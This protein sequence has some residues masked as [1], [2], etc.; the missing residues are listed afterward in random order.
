MMLVGTLVQL[1]FTV[2]VVNYSC[3]RCFH[4]DSVAADLGFVSGRI[5]RCSV[6]SRR[7]GKTVVIDQ[8]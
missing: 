8:T 6:L 4:G 7:E 2:W 1:D 3:R 5:I